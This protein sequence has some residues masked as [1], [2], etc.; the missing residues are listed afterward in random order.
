MRATGSS[1]AAVASWIGKTDSTIG[2]WRAGRVAA[3]FEALLRSGR[4]RRPL[5][6]YLMV[7]DRRVRNGRNGN[8]NTAKRTAPRMARVRG[9]R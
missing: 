4:L 6:R 5:L 7:C 9:G 1:R 8:G 3:D 2:N